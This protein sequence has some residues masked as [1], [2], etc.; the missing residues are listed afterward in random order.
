M[1]TV[2]PVTI[3]H[4]PKCSTSQKV[5]AMIREAGHEPKVIE[6]LAV[7][8]ELAT[9]SALLHSAGITPREALRVQGTNAEA[10]GLTQEGVSGQKILE[11]MV[12]H[13]VLVQRPIV[14][15]PKGVKLCRPAE[16]VREVL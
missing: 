16:T 5:L 1:S 7:G 3:Y 6:Y 10:L 11:E 8:W 4:N 12:V 15:S 9:L 13:P 14:V 2:F